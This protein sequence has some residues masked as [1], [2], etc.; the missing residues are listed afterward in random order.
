MTI[1]QKQYMDDNSFNELFDSLKEAIQIHKKQAIPSRVF[2]VTEPDVKE[3]R[4]LT[5]LKQTDFATALG[6]STSLV[7][8]WEQKRR[9][10]TGSSLKLLR[11]IEK[12]PNIA[13]SLILI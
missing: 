1:E 12:N 3:I 8:A 5:K 6:V 13:K 4:K 11:M 2:T 7:R 10:P 9:F